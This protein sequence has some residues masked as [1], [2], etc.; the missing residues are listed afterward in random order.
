VQWLTNLH[1]LDSIM[2]GCTISSCSVLF[3]ALGGD[4][5]S[6]LAPASLFVGTLSIGEAL[7]SPQ[8]YEYTYSIAPAGQEGRYFALGN[9]PLF[10]P[11]LFAGVLS[12]FALEKYCT[13]DDCTH[14]T[15]VWWLI[16]LSVFPCTLAM[17][18]LRV[19]SV[20]KK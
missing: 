17:A 18:A 8:F 11:K 14:G 20:I 15:R 6:S 10:L 9:V 13:V 4:T 3:L 5:H 2:L 12:G 1:P 19:M 7:W 16:W